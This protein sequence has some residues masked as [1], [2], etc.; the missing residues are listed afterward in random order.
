MKILIVSSE[1]TFVPNNYRGFLES[2]LSSLKTEIK[3]DKLDIQ[4]ALLKNNSLILPLKGLFFALIGARKIGMHLLMNSLAARFD[5]KKYLTQH[6]SVKI[7]YFENPNSDEFINFLTTQKIDLL[8][9]ARTRF[10]YKNKAL[11]IPRLAS[12]NIHHGLLPDFR[13][14]MCDLWALYEDRP[15]G[16]TIHKMEK[17]IDDGVIVRR[18][19]T[20]NAREKKDYAKLIEE[21]ARL[22]GEV[23]AQ[24]IRELKL[25]Q[26]IPIEMQNISTNVTYKKNPSF[27]VIR[28]ILAKGIKI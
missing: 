12:L 7:H 18:V 21:S 14:T 27:W 2:L 17:K 19:Q 24:L 5:D 26:K 15:T 28:K 23:T 10:I 11:K 9:N 16:F 4:I 13:G 20:S 25:S 1:V 3:E 8:I 6:F 22:E